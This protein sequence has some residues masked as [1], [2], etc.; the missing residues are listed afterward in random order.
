MIL[1]AFVFDFIPD[2]F[3]IFLFSLK[4][5][6]KGMLGTLASR[7]SRFKLEN[8]GDERKPIEFHKKNMK[9]KD[10]RHVANRQ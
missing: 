7:H 3:V 9:R 1:M 5:K 10:I 6:Q 2:K 8:V 4:K